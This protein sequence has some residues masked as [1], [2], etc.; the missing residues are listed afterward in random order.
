MK[1]SQVLDEL[2]KGI[3]RPAY[4]VVGAEPLLRD[5]ALSALETTILGNGPRDFNLDRLDVAQTTPGRLEE[6]LGSLPMMA[7][8]RLVVLR[9]AD[10]R[11][12]KLDAKWA[13][14]LEECVTAQESGASTIL[15]VVAAKVDK[16]QRWVKVFKEPA[17]MIECEAPTKSREIAAFLKEEAKRQ[18]VILDADA[19]GLLAERIGPQLLILR[20]EIEKA[21][22]VA[23][24]GVPIGREH[25][26]ASVASIADEPI[27]DLTDAIGQGRSAEAL[28]QLARM[29]G[30]GAAAPAVLGAL[31]SHFRKLVRAGHGESLSGSPY[32]VRKLEKQARR[33]PPR[34]LIVCLR[35]IHR[36]DV[37]L[38]GGSVM[39]PDRALEQLVLGLAS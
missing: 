22:L 18:G 4:L 27:W 33:Y 6:A 37:E 25:V 34:R 21:A 7:T 39:R 32:M 9:G 15:V 20:Q 14:R 11:G 36:A 35:A 38:K 13:E 28:D 31:A 16:R 2:A 23:G 1:V 30:R 24:L 8:H 17:A 26:A 12:G 29:L 5:Q 10:G 3:L 19:A